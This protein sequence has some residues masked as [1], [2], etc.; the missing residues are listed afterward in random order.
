MQI[1]NLQAMI[2]GRLWLAGFMAL[3]MALPT[4]AV[5]GAGEPPEPVTLTLKQGATAT[6]KEANITVT[7]TE[8]Q[9]LTSAG[10]LGGPQGCPDR[11]HI[12]VSSPESKQEL[13]LDVA[14]TEMQRKQGVH[15]AIVFGYRVTL[16]SVQQD[17]ATLVWEKW[18]R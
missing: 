3:C 2:K 10:C 1:V 5:S 15:Q 13:K 18:D 14:H 4:V 12:T 9:D 8:V 6:L 11:A 7:V 16:L 17:E